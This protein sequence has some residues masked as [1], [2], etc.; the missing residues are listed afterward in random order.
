MDGDM[1]QEGMTVYS[2]DGEKVGK[3]I[4]REGGILA[5]EKG[6]FFKKDYLATEDDVDRVEEDRVWLRRT[7]EELEAAPDMDDLED[8]PAP[9][10]SQRRDERPAMSASGEAPDEVMV[11]VEKIDVIA[12][13]VRRGRRDPSTGE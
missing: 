9:P 3:I 1:I 6:F 5:I 4:R 11:V 13:P 10:P 7:R 12:E 2:A 8:E